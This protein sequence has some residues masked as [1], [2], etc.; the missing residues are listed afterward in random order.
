MFFDLSKTYVAF[1][2]RCV[3]EVFQ[4]LLDYNL[5]WDLPIYIRFDD[6]D[7]ISRSHVC[8]NHKLQF[9]VAVRFLYAVI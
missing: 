4:T 8:L 9:F 1:G 5:A 6:L 7:L 2:G 3:R